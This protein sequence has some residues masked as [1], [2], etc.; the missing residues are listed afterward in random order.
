MSEGFGYRKE[1]RIIQLSLAGEIGHGLCV[2]NLAYRVAKELAL[3][4]DI[5]HDLVI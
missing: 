1:V 2:S 3:P 4:E 5:C